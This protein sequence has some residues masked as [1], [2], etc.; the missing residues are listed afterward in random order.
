MLALLLVGAVAA[1][2]SSAEGRPTEFTGMSSDDVGCVILYGSDMTYVVGP[3]GSSESEVIEP[4]DYTSFRIG[5][6]ATD[7]IVVAKS[8]GSGMDAS[9]PLDSIPEA[10][11]VLGQSEM[12]NG[13]DPGYKITCWRG[14][15]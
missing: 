12:R 1:G 5:R 8:E 6:T 15:S 7:V 2:C 9:T 11:A 3:L 13:G 4:N 14:E 10:G